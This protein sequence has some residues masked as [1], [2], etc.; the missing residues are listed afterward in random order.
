MKQTVV[1]IT[2]KATISYKEKKNI[3]GGGIG[4]YIK[5]T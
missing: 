5:K 2:S 4:L 1:V 3:N